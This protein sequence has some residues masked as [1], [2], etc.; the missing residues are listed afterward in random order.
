MFFL[1][2]FCSYLTAIKYVLEIF[3]NIFYHKVVIDINQ[4]RHMVLST[5]GLHC[6]PKHKSASLFSRQKHSSFATR[7]RA[8]HAG[9]M[10]SSRFHFVIDLAT[11]NTL[12]STINNYLI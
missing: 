9:E 6:G 5:F 4:C 3:L 10:S 1:R 8:V 7:L 2:K 11:S 12:Y